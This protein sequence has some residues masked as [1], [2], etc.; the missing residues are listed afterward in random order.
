MFILTRPL[1]DILVVALEQAV[2]APHCTARLAEAGARVVKVERPE[3]DFARRYDDVVDGESSYFVWLN[4]GK[5][6]ISLDLKAL[7]DLVL[8]RRMIAGADI[9]IQ[10]LAPG[11]T[12]RLGL[13]TRAMRELHPRLI[14]CD[15]SGYGEVGPYRDMKAYDLLIQCEAGLA[16]ITGTPDE[17]GRVGVSIVDIGCGMNAHAAILE[18][19]YDRKRT[20]MGKGITVSLFDTVADWM[21]VP[22]L[23]NRYGIAP[24]RVGISHAFIA[25]YGAYRTQD[26]E[27]IV[28]AVQNDREWARFHQ[29]LLPHLNAEELAL[30]AT[31]ALRSQHRLILEPI[32][33]TR[34]ERMSRDVAVTALRTADVA[35]GF[36]NNIGGLASHPQLRV[37]DVPGGVSVIA[38]AVQWSDRQPASHPVPDLDEHGTAIRSEFSG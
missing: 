2:A 37:I 5:E 10:N 13:S 21:N 8:M 17:P 26:G 6:S 9:F 30:F 1:Q 31:N 36:L 20:G 27:M 16:S 29:Y 15:I 14:T 4:R 34:F 3:G 35:Y 7:D 19:L 25:P 24:S 38:P 28:I 33:S 18:A 23:H 22:Y 12:D 11:A 32:I